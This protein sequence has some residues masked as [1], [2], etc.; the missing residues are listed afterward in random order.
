[1]A[2]YLQSRQL[3]T[4]G[5]GPTDYMKR[6]QVATLPPLAP[7]YQD[8]IRHARQIGNKLRENYDRYYTHLKYN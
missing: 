1:V 3:L 7:T 8:V 6:T 2:H 4:E 5:L